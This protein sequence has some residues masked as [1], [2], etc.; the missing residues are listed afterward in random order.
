MK[1]SATLTITSQSVSGSATSASLS[2]IG[3]GKEKRKS[4][5]ARLSRRKKQKGCDVE[6]LKALKTKKEEEVD[7]RNEIVLKEDVSNRNR[8]KDIT[9]KEEDDF[10]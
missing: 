8:K 2:R 3:R 6:M 10:F 9:T 4:K 7:A 5:F 1:S